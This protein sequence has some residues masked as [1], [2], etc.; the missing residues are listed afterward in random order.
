MPEGRPDLLPFVLLACTVL[1]AQDTVPALLSRGQTAWNESRTDDA[2]AAFE[3]AAAKDPTSLEAQLRLGAAHLQ[4]WVPDT[5]E[6]RQHGLKAEAAFRKALK[7]APANM[8]ALTSLEDYL[9]RSASGPGRVRQLEEAVSLAKRTIQ[10]APQDKTGYYHMGV[11]AWNRVNPELRA[12]REEPTV[13]GPLAD[14]AKRKAFRQQLLPIID[15]GLRHLEKALALDAKD[16]DVMGYTFMLYEERSF[17]ADSKEAFAADNRLA[18]TWW[19][20]SMEAKKAAADA[21]LK[22]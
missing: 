4:M 11:I 14:A 18:G 22:Q 2:I 10:A 16:M 12:A 19:V 8:E 9:V 17:L 21:V 6:V 3:K 13:M 7:L 20:K 15:D 5:P 1:A